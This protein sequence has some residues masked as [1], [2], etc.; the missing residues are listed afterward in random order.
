MIVGRSWGSAYETSAPFMILGLPGNSDT[1]VPSH[2]PA[3]VCLDEDAV[4]ADGTTAPVTK[5][6]MAYGAAPRLIQSHVFCVFWNLQS[7]PNR[8]ATAG[9][10]GTSGSILRS[11]S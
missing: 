1:V 3:H 10:S 6:N 5:P 2:R 8:I 9:S 11:R 4:V 7:R